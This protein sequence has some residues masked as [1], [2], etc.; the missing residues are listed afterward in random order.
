MNVHSI[1]RQSQS[2]KT[3]S[4]HARSLLLASVALLAGCGAQNPPQPQPPQV[5]VVTLKPQ[6]ATLTKDLPGRV[7][8]AE[9][10]EVRPQIS[11]VIRKRLFTE[12]S[13][14]KAGQVLYEIEDAP[15][16]AALATA[17]GNLASAQAAISSTQ[18][19]AE[20]YRSLAAINAVS[21]QDLDNA[22]TAAQ[23]ARASVAVQKAAVEAARINLN[24]TRIRA[25][26]SGHIGRSLFTAGALVQ[27]G[28]ADALATILRTDQVYVDVTQ[29][30]AQILDL[31]AA[32]AS[33][34]LSRNGDNSLRV[35]L[36]LPNGKVYPIEGK[37]QFSE[38]SVD[39]N[40]GTVTLRASFPNPD[41]VLLP[42]MYVR[43]RLVE[44]TVKDAILAPQQGITR[45]PR[46]RATALVVNAQNQVEQRIVTTGQTIGNTWLITSGL[47]AGDKLIVDGLTGLKTGETV[48]P[49]A[50][51]QTAPAAAKGH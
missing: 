20:R 41:G 35:Q 30:A 23:Q 17:Q 38:V 18:L 1:S 9:T 51:G 7:T 10:S 42:G 3:M 14:V 2:V 25:P 12:G 43:A 8:A 50:A 33:G 13:M 15:Y 6:P 31:K 49:G 46:G 24:F 34:E 4:F 5:G 21:K 47:K 40:T 16:R 44:G 29:S 27:N 32:I 28:Q 37:L 19:Q 39:E 11:G 22:V 45:D 36:I 48:T 26:I